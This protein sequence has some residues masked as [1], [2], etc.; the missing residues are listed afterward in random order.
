MLPSAVPSAL[1][2]TAV[3]FCPLMPGRLYSCIAAPQVAAPSADVSAMQQ[4]ME[5]MRQE[6]ERLKGGDKDAVMRPAAPAPAR[7][8]P[9]APAATAAPAAMAAP[10][11]LPKDWSKEIQSD[12][13]KVRQTRGISHPEDDLRP[14]SVIQK[15][16]CEHT[17]HKT[18]C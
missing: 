8:K 11:S 17:M 1:R 10:P 16:C 15:P 4:Q 7:A 2:R 5:A 6:L 18:T 12:T 9:A 3:F 13:L 14:K